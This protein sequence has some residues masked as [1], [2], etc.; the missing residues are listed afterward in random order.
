MSIAFPANIIAMIIV[1][2]I[3]VGT[4]AWF[5]LSHS[6]H[7]LSASL[8]FGQVWR[9]GAALVIA[10]WLLARLAVSILTPATGQLVDR[11]GL[12]VPIL[13]N[14]ITI[15]MLAGLLP[16]LVSP[17]FRQIVRAIPDTWLVGI[18]AFRIAG[19]LFLALLDMRLL[20][21]QF[22]LPAGYGYIT[23]GILA[24]GVVYL[25]AN[26]R[27]RARAAA[28]AWNLFG[29]LDFI[30]ALTTGIRF[31]GPFAAQVAASGI[32]LDYLNIVFII[33]SFGVPVYTLLH[34]YS[35][36]QLLSPKPAAQSK[37]VE[38]SRSEHTASEHKVISGE[39]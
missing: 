29:L 37:A 39:L 4:S 32:S 5:S 1:T 3:G 34:I 38:Q 35:L 24:L 23:T 13:L 26:H 2:M 14:F 33:P 21:P 8:R 28:I 19:V 11:S 25:L 12:S 30:T 31:I 10:A 36:Y 16:L 18:H 15:G 6:I 7:R 17:T 20:P 27:P 22:A 9:W